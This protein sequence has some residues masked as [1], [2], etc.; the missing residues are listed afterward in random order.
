MADLPPGGLLGQYRAS[1]PWERQRMLIGLATALVGP[2]AAFMI[3]WLL[4]GELWIGGIALF[5]YVLLLFAVTIVI[6]FIQLTHG[7]T[8]TPAGTRWENGQWLYI[9]RESERER[10]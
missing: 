3:G 4:S 6:G 10:I 9:P 8:P 2:I 5:S 7:S 1:Q